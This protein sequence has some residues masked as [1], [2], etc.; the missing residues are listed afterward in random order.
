MLLEELLDNA[1][2]EVQVQPLALLLRPLTLL[3]QSNSK[4]SDG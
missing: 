3:M 4:N 1:L 2:A